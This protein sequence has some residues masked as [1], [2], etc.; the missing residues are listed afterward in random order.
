MKRQRKIGRIVGEALLVSFLTLRLLAQDKSAPGQQPT[1]FRVTTELVLVNVVV[2]DKKGN[3]IAN[4][5][6][7]DFTVYEDGKKQDV[8]SF[9]FEDVN[10]WMTAG[11]AGPTV[12]GAAGETGSLLGPKKPIT[13]EAKDRRLMLLFF[14]FSAME[15]DDIDRAVESAKKFVQTKMQPAD[16]VAMVSLATSLNL[17][18]DFTDDRAKILTKLAAYNSS[19]GQ[20]FENGLTGSAE[21]AAETGGSY[22]PDDTDYNTFSADRKLL[23]LESVMQ[24]V[25]TIPQKKNLIYFSNGITQSGV[26]NQSALRT[27]TAAAVKANVSIYPVDVRGLQAFP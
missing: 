11:A 23:A 8:S 22:T 25:G 5:K 19:E 3:P 14:D 16:M 21:G 7:E 2:R 13:L 10:A 26:D 18:L 24:A 9:D 4:L 15:P 6:K 1:R 20:G 12:T 17:D 27:A